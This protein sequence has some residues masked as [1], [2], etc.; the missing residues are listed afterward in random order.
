MP[1]MAQASH[2]ESPALGC[3][4]D[5]ICQ[6]IARHV[7]SALLQ[8]VLL[9][10]KPGLVDQRNNGSHQDMSLDTFRRSTA[11]IGDSFA[12]FAGCGMRHASVPAESM[13]PLM[14]PIGLQAEQAMQAATRGVNTHKGGI[15][16][17]GLLS[18]AAGRLWQ[19][20]QSADEQGLCQLVAQFCHDLVAQELSGR[21]HSP[22]TTAGERLFQRY[23]LQGARGE[24]ASGYAT[25]RQHA[26]PVYRHLQQQGVDGETALLQTMLHLLAH[27]ADT[28]LVARG[29]L[30]GLAF[31]QSAARSLLQSGGVLQ[32]NG[33]EQ[34]MAMDDALIAR[35]LSPGGSA[36]LLGVTCFLASYCA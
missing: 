31:V 29:G 36:D 23:G 7:R 17:L 22:A 24:A 8:E 13:L 5:S 2:T 21:Q 14:R 16:S 30:A 26:L 32:K 12:L 34:L 27:N 35:R 6:G 11:A 15:F 4:A 1:S 20:G 28:N 19:N 33:R 25:V 10:P 9:T 18:A 3:M